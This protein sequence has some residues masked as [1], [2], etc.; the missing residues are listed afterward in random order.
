MNRRLRRWHRTA[1]LS[2]ALLWCYLALTGLLLRHAGEWSNQPVQLPWLQH[3]YGLADNN[4]AFSV[5]GQWVHG[6]HGQIW[7]E[8]QPLP[9]LDGTL[10]GAVRSGDLLWVVTEDGA[11]LVTQNGELVERLDLSLGFPSGCH[12]LANEQRVVACGDQHWQWDEDSLSVS[13]SQA[14]VTWQRPAA[15]PRSLADLGSSELRWLTVLRDLH[16]GILWGLPGTL[17]SDLAAIGLLL[18]AASGWWL[19]RRR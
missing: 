17:L 3:W 5:G 13:P 18:M 12:A 19:S 11:M 2:L 15:R 14:T 6:S 16:S 4:R 7:L 10:L 1:G 8:R 9:A